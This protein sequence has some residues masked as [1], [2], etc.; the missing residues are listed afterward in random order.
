[1]SAIDDSS[2][3]V[4]ID[5]KPESTSRLTRCS[6]CGRYNNV[7][8]PMVEGPAEIYICADCTEVAYGIVLQM[9]GH[10]AAGVD[11]I[12]DKPTPGSNL[13][14]PPIIMHPFRERHREGR[15]IRLAP[16]GT[17]A[18]PALLGFGERGSMDE[19]S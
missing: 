5:P 11:R 14:E 2:Q 19:L 1:M 16:Q 4:P 9:R 13:V 7:T 12:R 15:L 6:I 17:F 3:P 18:I 10:R 8:G